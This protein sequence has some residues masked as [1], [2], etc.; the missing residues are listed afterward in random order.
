MGYGYTTDVDVHCSLSTVKKL[1]RF[2]LR[3]ISLNA[4]LIKCNV[5][6]NNANVGKSIK[7]SNKNIIQKQKRFKYLPQFCLH[8]EIQ[9]FYLHSCNQAITFSTSAT[10][11]WQEYCNLTATPVIRNSRKAKTKYA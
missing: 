11:G 3:I 1:S 6:K 2:Q 10:N 4:L 7:T 8:I 5:P 9:Q